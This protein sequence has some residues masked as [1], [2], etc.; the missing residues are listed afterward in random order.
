MSTNASVAGALD[1]DALRRMI[2]AALPV[3]QQQAQLV[4]EMSDALTRGD[5]RAAL[6][7]ARRL[8]GL[9]SAEIVR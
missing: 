7:L 8:C 1:E 3:A 5:E 6:A 4:G 2:E 9:P